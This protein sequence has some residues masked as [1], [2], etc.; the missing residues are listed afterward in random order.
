MTSAMPP[1]G[2]YRKKPIVLPAIQ[3]RGPGDVDYVVG[4][5]GGPGRFRLATADELAVKP[6]N[7]A[8]VY[9]VLHSTWIGVK[10][11]DWIIRGVKGEHYPHDGPT[12][13]EVYDQV[14]DGDDMPGVPT[15]ADMLARYEKGLRAV[16]AKE[17]Y[18][19]HKA[20][21]CNEETGEDGYPAL[22]EQFARIVHAGPGAV[23]LDAAEA[24]VRDLLE[25]PTPPGVH[26]HTPRAIARAALTAAVHGIQAAKETT[27]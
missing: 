12:F 6:D 26:Y 2:R 11:G 9:D 24:A 19:L 8:Y 3:Y 20:I 4:F 1:S 15:L 17:D 5:V 16:I 22:A 25:S 13:V 7:T 14:A 27:Q 18:D 21:A 23:G 10:D